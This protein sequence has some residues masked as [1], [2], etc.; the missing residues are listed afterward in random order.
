MLELWALMMLLLLLEKDT[1]IHCVWCRFILKLFLCSFCGVEKKMKE[2]NLNVL[3]SGDPVNKEKAYS[4]H[5][6]VS[7]IQIEYDQK[8]SSFIRPF[9][10]SFMPC[11]AAIPSLS[12][13][14]QWWIVELLIEPTSDNDYINYQIRRVKPS[15][16]AWMSAWLHFN[17]NT[18]RRDPS[19]F[20]VYCSL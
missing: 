5:S 17:I 15:F 12:S 7:M 8:S 9:I 13:F 11:H 16:I 4:I 18:I 19:L 2:W 10:R 14:L 6:D 1:G 20:T 3:M